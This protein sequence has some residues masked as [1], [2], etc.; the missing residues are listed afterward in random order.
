MKN[1]ITRLIVLVSIFTFSVVGFGSIAQ[2]Q[3]NL[4]DLGLSD[5]AKKVGL[6]GGSPSGSGTNI[7]VVVGNT[8]AVVLN[9]LGLVF[10][11]LIVYSGVKWLTAQGNEQ[12]VDEAKG[13]LQHAIWGL[14]I[15]SV[16]YVFTYFVVARI[17]QVVISPVS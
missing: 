8:L 4:G 7:G 10:F 11:V 16:A 14:L 1:I 6:E 5:V 17:E 3:V 15:V 9:I 13:V 2:A 12:Q